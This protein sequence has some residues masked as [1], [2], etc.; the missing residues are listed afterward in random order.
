MN[1]VHL[2]PAQLGKCQLAFPLENVNRV[3]P[4]LSI[5]PLPGAPHFVSGVV[6]LYEQ[7]IA[8]I[9]LADVLKVQAAATQLWSPMLWVQTAKRDLILRVDSVNS[10]FSVPSSQ[11]QTLPEQKHSRW[12]N[13]ALALETGVLLIHDLE[14]LL[15]D[16][17]GECL[18]QALHDWVAERCL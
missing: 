11:L 10:P 8:V 12:F 17:D 14:Q 3:L 1:L 15:S 9:N 18:D 2:V 5:H 16:Y 7:F 4:L 6:N 13:G